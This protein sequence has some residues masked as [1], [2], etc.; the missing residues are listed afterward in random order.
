MPAARGTSIQVVSL[1]HYGGCVQL[2]YPTTPFCAYN[3]VAPLYTDPCQV[4]LKDLARVKN[5]ARCSLVTL[6]KFVQDQSRY[7]HFLKQ[8]GRLNGILPGD[9]TLRSTP[10]EKEPRVRRASSRTRHLP[11]CRK[12]KM[13]CRERRPICA[14][15]TG[16]SS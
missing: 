5:I 3:E 8:I 15:S 12:G 14:L 6:P 13:K 16:G 11:A 9:Y 2:F 10:T 1:L 7:K 4:A